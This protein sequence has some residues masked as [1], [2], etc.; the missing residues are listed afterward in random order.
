MENRT[1]PQLAGLFTFAHFGPTAVWAVTES[2]YGGT[3]RHEEWLEPSRLPRSQCAETKASL[4]RRVVCRLGGKERSA[5]MVSR[6]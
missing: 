6:H 2:R 5:G 4:H 1:A 3:M